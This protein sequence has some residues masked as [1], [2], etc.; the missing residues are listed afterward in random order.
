[1]AYYGLQKP[2]M[3]QYNRSTGVYSNGFT[4]GKAVSFEVT[5]N[6]AEGSL[7][8]DN[9]QAEYEK[10]FTNADVT[11][12]TST[13]PIDSASVVFGHTVD[14]TTGNITRKAS[15]EPNYVGTGVVIDEVVDGE[16]KYFAMVVT[17]AK[18]QEGAESFQTKGDSITFATPSISGKAIPD[19]NG[20]WLIRQEFSSESAALAYIKSMF[21]ISDASGSVASIGG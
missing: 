4:C 9:E 11:L 14:S 18:Y 13:L 16:K 19:K 6:Y 3:A 2:I 17:C 20:A 12:G 21:N 15:D 7:Y 5:P 8:A 10:T 1:M